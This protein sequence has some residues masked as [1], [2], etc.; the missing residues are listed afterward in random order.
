MRARGVIPED[1]LAKLRT[2]RVRSSPRRPA[3]GG[4]DSHH[5]ELGRRRRRQRQVSHPEVTSGEPAG[6]NGLPVGSLGHG[7]LLRSFPLPLHAGSRGVAGPASFLPL[8]LR[9]PD[10][11]FTSLLVGSFRGQPALDSRNFLDLSAPSIRNAYWLSIRISAVTAIVGG[12]FGFLLAYAVTPSGFAGLG[13]HRSDHL[14]RCGL[15]LRRRPAGL[16]LHPRYWGD[17]R[18]QSIL[19]NVHRG[20]TSTNSVSIL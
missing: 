11:P 2:C 16:R 3:G 15:E 8:H 10:R 5:R 17:G 12:A 4:Q 13:A 14:L 7:R 9:L 18:H 6:P 1:L 20:R 19:K